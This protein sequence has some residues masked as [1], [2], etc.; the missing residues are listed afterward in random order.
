MF[1]EL[2]K[3]DIIDKLIL[4]Y[5]NQ[6]FRY[7]GRGDEVSLLSRIVNINDLPSHDSRFPDMASDIW[8]HTVNNDD[9]DD[10]WFFTDSRI[11]IMHD[12][13]VFKKFL[14]QIFHPVVVENDSNWI[15][16]LEEINVI[17]RHDS[18]CLSP[19]DEMSGRPVYKVVPLETNRL[20]NDYSN[21]IK[22][23]FSS[24]FID[25]QVTIMINNIE[26][27]PNVAIGKAK[28]LL[29]SCAKSILDEMN[30]EYDEKIEVMPLMK[31]VME[32]LKLSTKTQDKNT[33][34]GEISSKILGNLSSISQNMASLRNAF[35]DGHGKSKSFV[36][37]PPRYARLAVGTSV[38]T[39][40]FLWETYEQKKE[41]F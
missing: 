32:K 20:I 4:G 17:L 31:L 37:L 39:V 40:Y 29:E 34:A 35:G 19:V 36:S 12:D 3:R 5:R 30:V 22:N 6:E 33:N 18:V 24:E 41:L 38:T 11:N 26:N 15:K 28:E 2:T 25:S 1:S 21:Q 8:Q 23:K 10:D 7:W 27:N 16:Y 9:W 14:E 13:E